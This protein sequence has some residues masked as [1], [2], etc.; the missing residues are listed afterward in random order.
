MSNRGLFGEH[1]FPVFDDTENDD[2]ELEDVVD[3]ESTEDEVPLSEDTEESFEDSEEL[4]EEQEEQSPEIT[5]RLNTIKG[6]NS[7][8]IE[9]TEADIDEYDGDL[10]EI[11]NAKKIKIAETQLQ[12]HLNTLDS[13]TSDAIKFLLAGGNVSELINVTNGIIGY[14]E[15]QILSDPDLQRKIITERE[16]GLGRSPKQIETYI[17]GLGD[18]LSDEAIEA[19]A[20]LKSKREKAIAAKQTEAASKRDSNKELLLKIKTVAS[21]EIDETNYFLPEIKVT[22]IVKEAAKKRMFDVF[23]E[24]YAQPEKYVAKLAFLK[25][26]GILDGDFKLFEKIKSTSVTKQ[27]KEAMKSPTTTRTNNPSRKDEVDY[28]KLFTKYLNK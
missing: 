5:E 6:L 23:N 27:L 4:E 15:E 22:P 7:V 10:Q 28:I 24:I 21:K 14:T 25:Q 1:I 16:K 26:Y 18:E 13:E 20:E 8:G 19:E 17:R 12:E 9:I 3:T 11:V 2:S